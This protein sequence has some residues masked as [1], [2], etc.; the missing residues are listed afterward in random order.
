[1]QNERQKL[2]KEL[3]KECVSVED[4]Q[5]KL[6]DLFKATLQE[7]FEAEMDQHLGYNKHNNEGDN[8]GNSRNGYS[9][10]TVKTRF[11]ESE[12]Q[13]PRDRNGHF[14]P[15]IV[16]KY[17]TTSNQLEEQ[18]IAMYAKGMST[19]D[20]EDHMR[21]IYGIDVSAA[22][23][24]KVTDKILPLI[25]EW[26]S[27]PLDRVYPIVFLDAIHFKVRKD[28]RII[29]KAAY[30]VMG[31]NMDGLKD[32]LG[33]WI[34]ENESASFWLGICNDL[35]NRGVEDIL[36]ACKDGLSGFSEAIS[37]V[38]PQTE[39]QLCV[40]HQ[41][42]NSLKYVSYKEQKE[43]IADLKKV[44]RALTIEEAELAF[45]VFKEKWG[46]KHPIIIR[47]WEKNWDE[48]TAFFKYPYEIRRII[49][50][51]NTIEGYHRQLRKVTKTKTAYPSDESLKKIIY[52]ATMEVSK[53]WNMPLREWK[54][55]VS[56]FHIY[57]SDRLEVELA[58]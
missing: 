54:K 41:I 20:I 44:Y 25:A 42:R 40:I 53:K 27:R 38:F 36:I 11:G 43:L 14:E 50:T 45:E 17:E 2:I 3:A 32:I 16:K 33:I 51:T 18:I 35:R 49:Y 6:R 30:S 55:C 57:F 19:R 10:K 48:L 28:N 15:K 46:K 9:K 8:T 29:N 22:T 47:S 58:L 39:I 56:Q 26:Q 1:M 21:D 52:L 24:S 34:G 37:S 5:K 12:V 23:V 7:I 4:V 31:I 13:I